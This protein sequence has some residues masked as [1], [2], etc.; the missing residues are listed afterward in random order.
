MRK[1]FGAKPFLYPMPVLI[2]AA[3]DEDGTPNAMNAAW[4]CI[5]DF[6][7]VAMYLSAEHKTVKNIL[8]KGTF[9][10]SMAD[11]AHVVEADYVGIVSGND[12]PDKVAKAGL[13]MTKSELVDAPVIDEFPMAL[14]CKLVSYDEESELLIGEIVNVCADESVL[15]EK[16][17]IDPAKLS[18]IT[19]DPVNHAYLKLGEKVGNAFKDGAK[20]KA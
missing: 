6:H 2:I 18:P 17:N 10:V 11:A 16:G 13:H 14:E 19:Y 3:Y 1:N 7:Q 20:L 15:D 9:T 4:G 8:S 5:A 12:V